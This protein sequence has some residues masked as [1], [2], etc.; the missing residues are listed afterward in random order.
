[1]EHLNLY[2]NF[3]DFGKRSTVSTEKRYGATCGMQDSECH[4]DAE[5]RLPISDHLR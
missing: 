4:Q 3:I 2:A 5:P 1:M